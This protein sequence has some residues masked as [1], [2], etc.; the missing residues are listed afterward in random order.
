MPLNQT[1]PKQTKPGILETINYNQIIC[2]IGAL[3]II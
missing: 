3:D 2:I 1:K